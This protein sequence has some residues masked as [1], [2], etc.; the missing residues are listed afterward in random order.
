MPKTLRRPL[1]Q[2]LVPLLLLAPAW[3]LARQPAA[4]VEAAVRE[5]LD[6][7]THGLASKVDLEISPLDA[8]NQL[9]PCAQLTAFLPPGTH[10]W[11]HISVGV[12]CLA[13]APWTVYV[14]AQV[15]VYG[16]YLVTGRALRGGQILGPADLVQRYG[17]LAAL[18][19]KLLR[20]PAQA[21]GQRTRYALTPG[22]PLRAEMLVLPPAIRQGE[23]VKVVAQGAGFQVS[24]R[25]RA[26]NT[27]ADGQSV[28]VRLEDGKVVTGTARNGGTVELDF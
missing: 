28:R 10:P 4:P 12:N 26:L 5:F 15:K 20:D 27:A 2:L 7:E 9:P 24:N 13:P 17:D 3:A 25:G 1:P 21:V 23:E 8:N 11:G 22:Q 6:A 18:P 16:D 14:P 19:D